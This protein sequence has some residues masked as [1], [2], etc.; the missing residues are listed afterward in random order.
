MKYN[1]VIFLLA[2]GLNPSLREKYAQNIIIYREAAIRA[3][4]T[5]TRPD[6]HIVFSTKKNRNVYLDAGI[7]NEI[8][9]CA[10]K[11]AGLNE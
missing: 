10:D 3:G 4:R 2:R 8:R 6:Y 1:R 11:R 9:K 7:L 5:N